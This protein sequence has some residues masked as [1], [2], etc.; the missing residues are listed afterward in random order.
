LTN[1]RFHTTAST[2]ACA[3]AQNPQPGA[4]PEVFAGH[5][6]ERSDEVRS[7][8]AGSRPRPR[9]GRAIW[10]KQARVWDCPSCF[11][12]DE[13]SSRHLSGRTSAEIAS[14]WLSGY[15][16]DSPFPWRGV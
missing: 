12:Q 15:F 10:S 14:Q 5:R 11:W 7:R 13:V 1:S 8:W 3:S 6:E 4:V 9:R 16:W 2:W